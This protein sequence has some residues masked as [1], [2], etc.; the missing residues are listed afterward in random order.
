[1]AV[2]GEMTV[3]FKTRIPDDKNRDR[4]ATMPKRSL[5]HGERANAQIR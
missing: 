2:E 1:M 4:E 3:P 5:G